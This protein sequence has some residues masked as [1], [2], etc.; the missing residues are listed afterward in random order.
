V[1]AQVMTFLMRGRPGADPVVQRAAAVGRWFATVVLRSLAN[2]AVQHRAAVGELFVIGEARLSKITATLRDIDAAIAERAA[3]PASKVA[4]EA[5]TFWMTQGSKLKDLQVRPVPRSVA[6]ASV[7]VAVSA[8]AFGLALWSLFDGDE[9]RVDE[10]FGFASAAV[11]LGE[12]AGRLLEFVYKGAPPRLT[13]VTGDNPLQSFDRSVK[14][15]ASIGAFLGVPANTVRFL[16]A[17]QK[18]NNWQMM[19]EVGGAAG[20]VAVGVGQAMMGPLQVAEKAAGQWLARYGAMT[21]AFGVALGIAAFLGQIYYDMFVDIGTWSVM[22]TMLDRLE[23]MPRARPHANDI[24]TL[25]RLVSDFSQCLTPLLPI[26]GYATDD[27]ST[28]PPTYWKAAKLGYSERAIANLFD[29]GMPT[30]ATHLQPF[31]A[32]RDSAEVES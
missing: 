8:A 32:E 3:K 6:G 22:T 17:F 26:V 13:W 14:H 27:P 30:V 24:E 1:V 31:F 29:V 10:Y 21:N 12:H 4:G 28:D 5:A 2:D 7:R 25:R 19:L 15:L 16:V 18:Y 20:N 11:N 23:A 9:F